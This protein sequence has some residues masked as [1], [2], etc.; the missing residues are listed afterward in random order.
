MPRADAARLAGRAKP[1]K[2]TSERARDDRN[3]A[4]VLLW[5][6]N[7]APHLSIKDADLPTVAVGTLSRKDWP[8]PDQLANTE[9]DG[10]CRPAGVLPSMKKLRAQV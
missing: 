5:T 8:S 3:R 10:D 9:A 2:P 4:H 7:T 6:D 1:R